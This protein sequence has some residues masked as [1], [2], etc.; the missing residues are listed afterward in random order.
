MKREDEKERTISRSR[1]R[2][3][4]RGI[5]YLLQIQDIIETEQRKDGERA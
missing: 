3:R 4:R 5:F 1:H 2:S